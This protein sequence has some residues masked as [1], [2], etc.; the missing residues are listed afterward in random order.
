MYISK[1][2]TAISLT[3]LILHSIAGKTQRAALQ[4]LQQSKEAYQQKLP[5]LYDHISKALEI[6]PYHQVYVSKSFGGSA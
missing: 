1:F 2:K 3:I 4:E 5:Y 6:H